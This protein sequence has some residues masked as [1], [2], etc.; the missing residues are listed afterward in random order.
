MAGNEGEAQ[1]P[2]VAWDRVGKVLGDMA[3]VAESVWKRNLTV[4]N[5]VSQNIRKEN[6]GA[7]EMAKDTATA[8]A[9]ALDNVD[10]IWSSLTRP[11][12]TELVARPVPTA[13]LYFAWQDADGYSPAEPVWI[14][15]PRRELDGLPKDAAVIEL[16]APEGVQNALRVRQE[17]PKG[18]VV[19]SAN[20]GGLE[21]GTYSGAV[22]VATDRRPRVLAN[23]RVVV[24]GEKRPEEH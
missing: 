7:N 6:Y 9:A 17:A 1:S 11:P 10:D 18:Y 2:E 5:T 16:H 19:E 15:V 14:L 3:S 22:Y 24:E 21:P 4:W 13:F 20:L 23:L 12:E 8:M